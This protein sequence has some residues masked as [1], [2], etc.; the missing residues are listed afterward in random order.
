[1]PGF[2]PEGDPR[3]KAFPERGRWEHVGFIPAGFSA[4][5]VVMGRVP[6]EPQSDNDMPAYTP[7]T[8]R[9][10]KKGK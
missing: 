8:G 4:E 3:E 10:A 7:E 1:M 5:D 9:K 2:I 6:Q